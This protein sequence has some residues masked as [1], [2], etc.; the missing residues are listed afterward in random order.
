MTASHNSGTSRRA[1]FLDRDGTL[2]VEV[3]YLHR[4]KDLVLVPGAAAAIRSLSQAGFSVIVVTNQAGIAR[5]Y[6][7]ETALHTLHEEI[8]RRLA[9]EG[10]QIDAFY[11]CP[12]HPDFGGACE[13]RKPAPGMLKQAAQD[14]AIDLTHS[15]LIG[16]TSGDIGAGSAVGCRTI[17]VRSGYGAQAE[18]A[19]GSGITP[20][21]E[22][23]V[24]DLS[25]AA[26]YILSHDHG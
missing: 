2:N 8:Q 21:P 5:G 10:A 19:L 7:D 18:A 13:C 22:A 24:D 17:L 12:H 20:Q 16:D 1:V 14:H 25:A 3:N 11:F 23:I 4:I 9:A 6:Y 26:G 15:W